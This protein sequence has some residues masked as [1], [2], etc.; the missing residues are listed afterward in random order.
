MRNMTKYDLNLHIPQRIENML[1]I[2]E[3]GGT[4]EQF[5]DIL[6]NIKIMINDDGVIQDLKGYEKQKD[7]QLK[8][9][10]EDYK[11]KLSNIIQD[12]D[13]KNIMIEFSEII[14]T[15][16]KDINEI[17]NNYVDTVKTYILAFVPQ[18]EFKSYEQ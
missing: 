9:I 11:K 18:I 8:E 1:N 10:D 3:N 4:L 2:I 14:K 5:N 12:N 6:D 13:F 7:S 16:E 17:N 15:Y